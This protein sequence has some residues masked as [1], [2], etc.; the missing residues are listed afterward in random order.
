M[1]DRPIDSLRGVGKQKSADLV[2]AG[3]YTFQ[4]LIYCLPKSYE[5]RRNPTPIVNIFGE[6]KYFVAGKV[7]NKKFKYKGRKSLLT[8]DVEDHSGGVLRV[9]FF[10]GIYVNNMIH[11]GEEYSFF[12]S[13]YYNGGWMQMVHPEFAVVGSPDDV[14]GILPVYGDIGRVK[15]RQIRNF[16]NQINSIEPLKDTP[17]W[18]DDRIIERANVCTTSYALEG[19]HFP[20]GKK[21]ILEGKYRLVFDELLALETG[22]LL[23]K[24][25][26]GRNENGVKISPRHM[27]EYVK[28]LPFSLTKD[29]KIALKEIAEDLGSSS[30]MNRLI[31][32]DVGSGKTAIA[33]VSMYTAAKEGY[34]S[35]FMAPTEIL[36]KQHYE[37]IGSSFQSHGIRCGLLVSK[38]SKK[39]RDRILSDLKCG[40][41]DV[42]IGTHAL[43]GDG[44]K[45]HKLGLVITDEQH[46][47][48]VNQ[49]QILTEK[50]Q[51]PNIMVMTA[52]PIPRTMAVVV[53]GDLDISVI[54]SMP[55]GRKKIITKVAKDTFDRESVY[56]KVRDELTAGRQGYVISPLIEDSDVIE[57]SSANKLYEEMRER[58]P[59][60]NVSLLHGKMSTDEKSK[61][62]EDFYK[63]EVDLLVSTVVIEVG[64][65]VPNATVMV[66]ENSERFGLA[67]LHQLRGRV[68]RGK[69]QSYCFLILNSNS[70]TSKQ[71]A[72]IMEK[73]SDGFVI[74]EEDLNLRGPGDI[75]GTRQHGLPNLRFANLTKHVD[76]LQNALKIA[77][78]ILSEDPTLSM[79][80][81]CQLKDRVRQLYGDGV[82]LVL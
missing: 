41:I 3:I 24:G 4:D 29:Q 37:S 72:E 18:L 52:T 35:V 80:K 45:F 28:T 42:I 12:G 22:L 71:R 79:E 6:G 69:F 66:I 34:Q 65:N 54:K 43:L 74:A 61:V 25:T 70:E 7:K 59:D 62:M 40:K 75:L 47:F 1:N 30:A 82:N 21:E 33:E 58:F 14:R 23:I 13:V 53:Y 57:A 63:G 60:F 26:Y 73:T 17:E 32:G 5:D 8:F 50:G 46:R 15:G 64:I 27:E 39:L 16:I 49:R 2:K 76:V 36:A 38:Q 67:Q 10:N 31:Q 51:N 68:G 48:G 78:D 44:V 11:Q 77:K 9:I 81:N 19:I 55:K 56:S 20:K